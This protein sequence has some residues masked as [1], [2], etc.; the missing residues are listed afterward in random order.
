MKLWS[1]YIKEMKIASRGFYFYIEIVIAVI[2]LVILLVVV[3]EN[4]D[5][6]SEEYLYNDIPEEVMA[7][8]YDRDI[9]SGD[10]RRL[11]DSDLTIKP[12]SFVILNK[13]T[14][15]EEAYEFEDEKVVTAKSYEKLNRET[16]E[17]LGIAYILEDELDMIRLSYNTGRIGASTTMDAEGNYSYDYFLQGYELGRYE[18]VLYL[19]HTFSKA[20]I[21]EV[22]ERQAIRVIGGSERLNNREVVVPVYIAFSGSLMGFIIIMSYIFLDKG[23]GVI[24]AFAV[25]PSSVWHYLFSK[26]LVIL[27]TVLISSSIVVMPIMKLKPNYVLFYVYLIAS[28]FLFS[29][30]GLLV[31]SFFDNISKAFG[32]LYLLMMGLMLPAFS[33]FISSFDPLWIRFLPTYPLLEGFKGIMRGQ[34]EVTYVLTYSAIFIVGGFIL[35]ALAN[36]K[37]KKSLTQ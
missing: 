19:L 5:G 11:E 21:N 20:A 36:V 29:C 9:K 28:S 4:P 16:G 2:A 33:Y 25:T 12:S 17:V 6:K 30:L 34:G 3:Q 18:D 13:E 22:K 8:L 37:F 26:T 23:E 32:V 7:Y 1:T 15:Q 24:K 27:T 14:G 35:L 10:I 31:A